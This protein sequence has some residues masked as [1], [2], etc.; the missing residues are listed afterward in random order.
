MNYSFR[1]LIWQRSTLALIVIVF[2]CVSK[3]AS[4]FP[5]LLDR[6]S[7]PQLEYALNNP[8]NPAKVPKT[9]ADLNFRHRNFAAQ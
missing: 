3:L 1:E 6:L 4:P 2:V 9:S 7:H 5:G 8:A